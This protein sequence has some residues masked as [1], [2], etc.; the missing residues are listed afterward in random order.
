MENSAERFRK[1]GAV[2]V[3]MPES[4][5][6]Y[7][8]G[9]RRQYDPAMAHIMPHITLVFAPDLDASHWF[10]HHPRIEAALGR[11]QAFDVHVSRVATF[12]RTLCCGC[13]QQIATASCSG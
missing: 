12:P 6:K 4:A 7:V 8:D 9:F 5:T 2:T 11:I 3:T 10:S 1:G 13:S